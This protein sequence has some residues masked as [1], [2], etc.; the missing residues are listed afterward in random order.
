M[1]AARPWWSSAPADRRWRRW[2]LQLSEHGRV[3]LAQS[4]EE[5]RSLEQL[6]QGNVT[7]RI[8]ALF[9]FAHLIEAIDRV[10]HLDPL[11][12]QQHSAM[13]QHYRPLATLTLPPA[14][15]CADHLAAAEIDVEA[16][17]TECALD[18]AQRRGTA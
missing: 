15:S 3:A 14:L 5:L 10:D 13:R 4:V 17:V 8:T 9:E 18:L 12:I 2:P 16:T 11:V 6:V 1:C 7:V